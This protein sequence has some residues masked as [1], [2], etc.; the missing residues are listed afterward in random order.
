[1]LTSLTKNIKV[2]F[3]TRL[4]NIILIQICFIFAAIVLVIFFQKESNVHHVDYLTLKKHYETLGLRL[5]KIISDR[6][7][8]SAFNL[9]NDDIQRSFSAVLDTSK[10]L[11]AYLYLQQSSGKTARIF[12]LR[13][14]STAENDIKEYSYS[15][16]VDN[17]II[18][19]EMNRASDNLI[20]VIPNQN[21]IVYYYHFKINDTYN[22]ILVTVAKHEY[23]LNQRNE[24]I[25]TFGLLFLVSIFITLLVIYL[26]DMRFKTPLKQVLKG[27]EKTTQGELYYMVETDET[28]ELDD[29]S[30]AFNTM[31]KTLYQNDQQL[32]EYNTRLESSN[33][34]LKDSQEYLNRL[35]DHSP[36]S[37]ISTS[38]DGEIVVFNR[39]AVEE[40]GWTTEAIT[41]KHIN[42]LFTHSLKEY[43]AQ[44]ASQD[45]DGVEILCKRKDGSYFPAY[46]VNTPIK[47]SNGQEIAMLFILKDISESNN[48][49]D[50]MIRLDR[51]YTRGQMAGDIAHEIN[52]FLT[53]LSGNIE[54]LPLLIKKNDAEKL[55]KKITLMRTTI[56]RIANFTDG[57]MDV[58][59]GEARF[60]KTD[61]NQLIESVLTFL[62]PQNKFDA[63]TVETD[64]STDIPLVELDPGQLQQLLV[65]LIYNA[66]DVLK[67][68]DGEKKIIVHTSLVPKA[69]DTE[70]TAV[71]VRV[72]DT[73]AGVPEEKIPALFE[74][75]FTT[76]RKGH[77][78]GLITCKKIADKH[79]GTIT[80]TKIKGACFLFTL[81]VT[82]ISAKAVSEIDTA[83][84]TVPSP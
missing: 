61:I 34:K 35:I 21:N 13:D 72:C 16:L 36:N 32:K 60:V 10:L 74:K 62:K 26:I 19:Y 81:P 39:M 53:I 17:S 38:P 58:G 14:Y 71:M 40:F 45:T 70:P 59:E 73:G 84:V 9:R 63:I 20:Q 15:S 48:F 4:S 11:Q 30:Q 52:N 66:G 47:D 65:N 78:I 80:Y 42:T 76:K 37:I 69:S 83:P 46:M 77:G 82:Q 3:L 79:N 18:E 6:S 33:N 64:L 44:M 56:D 67:D 43:H 2:D 68:W 75:R 31:V 55:D 51:Y 29:L 24:L 25:Y 8:E 41:G 49:K 23:I 5:E 22:A 57:L 7:D 28:N 54:L 1:M 50:M 27:L 12:T